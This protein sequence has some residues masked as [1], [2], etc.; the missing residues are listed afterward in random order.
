MLLGLE[1]RFGRNRVKQSQ[2]SAFLAK[3]RLEAPALDVVVR[4]VRSFLEMPLSQA[5]KRQAKRLLLEQVQIFSSISSISKSSRLLPARCD[6]FFGYQ[7][8]IEPGVVGLRSSSAAEGR[9]ILAMKGG[10]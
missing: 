4:E 6:Y 3:N 7:S 9:Q 10:S 1:D 2:W 5:S 8:V